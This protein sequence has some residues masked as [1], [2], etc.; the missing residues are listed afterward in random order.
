MA[1]A[2]QAQGL[3]EQDVATG[4]PDAGPGPRGPGPRR[5]GELLVERNA[6]Q[7][8]DVTRALQIQQSVGG[9]LGALLVRTGALS[10]DI[11]LR[12]LADQQGAVYLRD[13]DDLPDSLAVYR[14][15]CDAPIK[16]DWFLDHSALLW[17]DAGQLRCL[18]RDIQDRGLLETL[19][20]FYPGRAVSFHL[21]AS[22]QID[23]FLDF[24]RKER[25]IENLF[26]D[27]NAKQLREMAEEAPVIELVNN[28]LSQA[29]DLEAS[30][31]HVEPAAENFVVRMR[32]D[33]VLH[34]RLTQPVER[35]PA[36]ASRIKLVSGIDIAER[37]LPQDGRITERISGKDMDVR[38]STVP[39]AFGES[40][41]LR[42]LEKERDDLTLA[43]LGMEPDHLEMFRGW[44]RA[45]NG[46]VLVTG[47][48][49]SGKSTTLAGALQEIDDGVKKI[50]T[51]EDP[52]E[53][54][55]PSIIQI[56]THAE[57]G[58]TF[59]RALR[60]I[61]RQDP[62]VIMIGEIRDLETAEI[63]IRSALTGHVVLSTV[64]TNDA[65]SSFTRLVDMGVEPFLVAAP[66]RGV[67]AQRL[68][69][70]ACEHCAVPVSAPALAQEHL[71]D[72]GPGARFVRQDWVRVEGCD[73]CQHTGYRGRMGIYELVPMSDELQ[74]MIVGGA[75]LND[76]KRLAHQE[77]GH[78]TLLQDGLIKASQG[79]TTV[80]EVSRLTLTGGGGTG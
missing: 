4:P 5:L 75:N 60:A 32:V 18:A 20:Y 21:A 50:I 26:S 43:N 31:I 8:D 23:R 30:D 15:L 37:R 36:V 76:L 61:L 41:V 22:H 24:I 62:D 1:E 67:Q 52:V 69:R 63:A 3:R 79:R 6:V 10:E 51:V 28:L 59:A 27:D 46:I 77:Q 17:E 45:S 14:F 57:I 70:R 19:A 34:T 40:I 42:L 9:K 12:T 29:V 73:A 2:H 66:T 25:A 16:L 54:Q 55:M 80:E 74:N 35:F 47:P 72:L 44:S 68:V 49:G 13:A 78:R 71:A 65:I 11:L 53:I 58:Y 33:G 64:H 7:S 56:Q 38:V 48:T 39:C